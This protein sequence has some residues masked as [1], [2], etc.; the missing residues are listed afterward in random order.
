MI[1]HVPAGLA[2]ASKDVGVAPIEVYLNSRGPYVGGKSVPAAD[3]PKIVRK[4]RA[5]SAVLCAEPDLPRERV[6]EVVALIKKGG[7]R[8]VKLTE[9]RSADELQAEKF[10][11]IAERQEGDVLKV[12][13]SSRGTYIN[14]KSIKEGELPTVVRSLGTKVVVLTVEPDLPREKV[15][16][17]KELVRRGGAKKV[18]TA[19]PPARSAK[20]EKTN[21]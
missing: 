14:G 12:Y 1:V 2:A 4:S 16:K 7:V 17:V 9:P 13:L 21:R 3:L 11:V 20:E 19:A 10:R 8:K 15:A 5:R 18:R 6:R